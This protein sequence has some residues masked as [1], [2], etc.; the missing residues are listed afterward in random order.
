MTTL[1]AFHLPGLE[2][3]DVAR[4]EFRDFDAFRLRW[5]RLHPAGLSRQ[6]ARLRAARAAALRDMPAER[7]LERIAAAAERLCDP[8]LSLR[9]TAEEA[10]P[11][12]TGYSR[13][14]VRL[15]LDRMAPDWTAAALDRLLRAELPDPRVLDRFRPHPDAAQTWVRAFGPALAFH[16]FSGNVPGVAVTAILRAL[17]VKAAVLGKTASGEP[18]LAPLF[19]RALA[20]VDPALGRT[21]ALTYWPGGTEAL[22]EVAFREADAVV[23]YGGEEVEREARRRME[24]GARL[25]VHGPRY[26]LGL[27][28]REALS[29]VAAPA[30][31]R[32]VARAVAIFD[33]HGCVSPHLVYAERGAAVAPRAF[34][35]LIADAL[36]TLE[37]E[38]PRGP[39]TGA[40]AALIHQE[41]AAAEFRGHAGGAGEVLA[42]SGT[43]FTVAYE[44]SPRFE[45]SCLNR[46][47]RVKPLDELDDAAGHV[48]PFGRYLQ[49]VGLAVDT[50]RAAALAEAFGRLGASRIA[51]FD[52]VPWPPPSWHHDGRGPLREL[53]RWTDMEP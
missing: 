42:G 20:A 15:I 40:E 51:P 21:V 26:S 12:I 53:L 52:A 36:R 14:M 34:A 22:E 11:A 17:L 2:E 35:R 6:V 39:I 3:G 49:T 47:L 16:V 44:E 41:R 30:V 31:A 8:A 25:V 37:E 45:P 10:L 9:A 13:P 38:L 1:D 29:E 32:A 46:F 27:V 19:A 43:S 18:L 48:R 4:W 33:Q 5:P 24:V 28:G 7:V 50:G 23:V